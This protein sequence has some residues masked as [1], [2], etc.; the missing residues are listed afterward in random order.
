[1]AN[2]LCLYLYPTPD[3]SG[4]CEARCGVYVEGRGPVPVLSGVGLY[5]QDDDDDRDFLMQVTRGNQ[6]RH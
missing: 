4:M 1:M 2:Q 6:R 3:A 5:V